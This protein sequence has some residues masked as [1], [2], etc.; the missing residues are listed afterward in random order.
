M[1]TLV[2]VTEIK[3]M[4]GD[5]KTETGGIGIEMMNEEGR[6]E[7]TPVV[8]IEMRTHAKRGEKD[9]LMIQETMLITDVKNVLKTILR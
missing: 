1:T 5:V 9:W 7:M 8:R 6:I 4:T 3:T 2:D